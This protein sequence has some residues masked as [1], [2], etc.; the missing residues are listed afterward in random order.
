VTQRIELADISDYALE[1]E[2]V[3]EQLELLQQEARI[4]SNAEE[5]E[6][7]ER[8][9]RQLTDR[10]GSLLLGKKIQES[11]DSSEGEE[12]EEELMKGIPQ[13]F[14]SEG[15][16]PVHIDTSFGY[17]ITVWVRH[18][19]RNCDKKRKKRHKG[20]YAGLILLGICERC[21]PH[22]SSEVGVLA[23]MLGSFDVCDRLMACFS[24]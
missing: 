5:L 16:K 11:L 19:L 9:I 1:I 3:Y 17:Q 14:K 12:A 20:L 10:L 15:K 13:K 23:A 6:E 7:L 24:P 22:F 18:Y 8:E 4:V 21:T 2:K